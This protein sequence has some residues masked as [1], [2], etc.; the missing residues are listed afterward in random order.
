MVSYNFPFTGTETFR[1]VIQ[2]LELLR[3]VS[4]NFPFTGTETL[5]LGFDGRIVACV[6]YNFP[7]TG[8]ETY[9]TWYN[10]TSN[11]CFIQLPLHGDG[12][13]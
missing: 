1:A 2:D 7:F 5:I 8:T 9:W 11:Y 6:S 10:H 3:R 4:Y 13:S 12:N